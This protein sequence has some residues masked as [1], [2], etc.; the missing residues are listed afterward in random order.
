MENFQT[1]PY[2]LSLQTPFSFFPPPSPSGYKI[3]TK[4]SLSLSPSLYRLFVLNRCSPV[5]PVPPLHL[6]PRSCPISCHT[7]QTIHTHP[8]PERTTALEHVRGKRNEYSKKKKKKIRERVGRTREIGKLGRWLSSLASS[9]NL[10]RP[11]LPSLYSNFHR[12]LICRVSPARS[13]PDVCAREHVFVTLPL[14][15]LAQVWAHAS[16]VR[17]HKVSMSGAM[18]PGLACTRYSIR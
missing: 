15:S 2:C 13:R 4:P 12:H 17:S 1:L 7:L 16:P 5:P 9:P 14:I 10:T 18:W 8:L 6:F 11:H 3:L